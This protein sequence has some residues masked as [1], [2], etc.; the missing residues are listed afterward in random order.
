MKAHIFACF[1]SLVVL[2]PAV[3]SG[4]DTSCQA[5][6]EQRAAAL[7]R[8]TTASEDAEHHQQTLTTLLQQ[9]RETK[10][11]R[12]RKEL[13]GRVDRVQESLDGAV[14]REHV[15]SDELSAVERQI[16]KQRCARRPR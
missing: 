16:K 13:L 8:L 1:I 14:T 4:A 2:I 10:S 11:E 3:A 6:S 15:S 9:L 5:L 7:S 12:R